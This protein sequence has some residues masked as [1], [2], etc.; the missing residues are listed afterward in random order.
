MRKPT[1]PLTIL[2]WFVCS[3]THW[4]H[5]GLNDWDKLTL[6][7]LFALAHP[8]PI[9]FWSF[10]TMFT[11]WPSYRI[12]YLYVAGNERS[13]GCAW[14][15]KA[16]HAERNLTRRWKIEITCYYHFSIFVCLHQSFRRIIEVIILDLIVIHFHWWR[17]I[18]TLPNVFAVVETFYREFVFIVKSSIVI[19]V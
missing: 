9:F 12:G 8:T 18:R 1:W 14:K 15:R 17:H 3:S 19:Y 2:S 6:P 16:L 7:E 5:D 10:Q 4:V 13:C 11:K